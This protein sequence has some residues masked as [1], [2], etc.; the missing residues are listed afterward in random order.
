[1]SMQLPVLKGF[2]GYKAP[3]LGSDITAGLAIAA[4]AIPSAIAY[5]AIAGLPPEMGVYASILSLVG[6]AL[7]GPSRKLIVGPDAA[8][9]IVLAAVLDRMAASTQ[10]DRAVAAA[11]L[12]VTVGLFCIV[13]SKLRLGVIAAFLS[14]PILV[15]FISGIAIS[16]LIG[17]IG[18]LTG[19]RIESDGLFP[20]LIELFQKADLIH[21]PSVAFGGA[22]FI[23]LLVL[24]RW[25]TPVPGPL[26]VVVLAVVASAL[27]DFESMGMKVVG[28]LPEALPS[29]SLPIEAGLP[30]RELLLGAGAVWLVS[31]S[32]GIVSARSFGARDKFEVDANAELVGLGGA[33]IASGLFSGFPITTSDSRTAINLSV[34]GQSQMAGLVAAATLT[35]MLLYLNDALRLLPAPAL[36][37]ILAAAAVGLIDLAGLREIWRISRMEFVF[38]LI[39]MAGAISL[40]VLDGVIIAVS[41]TLLYVLLK[42]MR[43]RDAMLGRIPGR[44]GFYKLHRSK[45]AKPIPGVAVCVIQ[46]SILF[47]TS[48]MSK[49]GSR[50]SPRRC[51]LTPDG[52]CSTAAR[53]LKSIRR[54]RQCWTTCAPV[55]PNAAWRWD[56]PNCIRSPWSS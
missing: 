13:A 52:S 25:R 16:I 56:S 19:V 15:G 44:P 48:N 7:L 33:N 36:G 32:S 8:T 27:L 39:G 9:M 5:P 37:A 35:A 51:R 49:T 41:A 17:Q 55:S 23:L 11:A 42:G 34:G 45:E 3:W 38:A 50:R 10:A 31:F 53:S 4:V 1:M 30:I 28:S 18:R 43:P 14:R 20:P 47:S 2:A 26:V 46:G 40:G 22:M 6:Y 21:W 24:T 12:A 54:Q 29:L